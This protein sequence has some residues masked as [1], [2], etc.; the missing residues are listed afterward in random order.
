M[1][2]KRAAACTTENKPFAKRL[3]SLMVE[4]GENQKEL[5]EELGV[6]QQ[7][8]SYYRNGQST[9]DA[10]NL[11]KIAR[12]Y[13]VTT[14]FLLGLTEVSTTDTDLKAVC[15]YTGL[16]EG[17]VKVLHEQTESYLIPH[18]I[19]IYN[20]L[21][22]NE[23]FNQQICLDLYRLMK[24]KESMINDDSIETTITD[25]IR[26]RAK[27]EKES[28]SI[29]TITST[30]DIV[31]SI[32]FSVNNSIMKLVEEFTDYSNTVK[33]IEAKIAKNAEILW[34]GEWST[35]KPERKEEILSI[36]S[37][38]MGLILDEL[39]KETIK[40]GETNA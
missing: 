31:N 4:C 36:L 18:I 26:S 27:L 39:V 12:H 38:C 32:Y 15:E 19:D 14:D 2:G 29:F 10:D 13:G 23:N 1:T 24:Y 30:L 11:I 6:K 33:T 28:C 17:A 9:P 37:E 7:T 35:D 34:G 40:G 25:V 22:C 5:A 20:R 3:C 16:C 21:I 8:I